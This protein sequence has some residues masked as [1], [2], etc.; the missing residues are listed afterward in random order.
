MNPER[1]KVDDLLSNEFFVKWV[2][3]PSEDLDH[4]WSNWIHD[5]PERKSDIEAARL[6]VNG[7]KYEKQ[8][9]LSDEDDNQILTNILHYRHHTA[10]QRKHISFLVS[11]PILKVAAI[12]VLIGTFLLVLIDNGEDTLMTQQEIIKHA[13]RG[14]KLTVFLPEGTKVI[15]NSDSE[16]R[17]QLPFTDV[18]EVSLIGEAFFEVQ[19]DPEKPFIVKAD[20]ITTTVLGTSFNVRSYPEEEQRTISVITGKVK[21]EDGYGHEE[22]LNP[23]IQG[24]LHVE[25]RDLLVSQFD[26]KTV[27]GWKDGLLVF[28][29]TPLEEVFKVLSRRY[30]VDFIISDDTKLKGAYSGEYTGASLDKVLKG[31]SLTSGFNYSLSNDTVTIQPKK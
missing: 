23:N 26:P 15:L 1:H 11:I 24:V 14:Q 31:I 18:R 5:H 22:S 2:H 16:I 17:Y 19:R 20:Q 29:Q 9:I 10:S 27:V 13:K 7:V 30:G 12:L 21:I 8:S 6:V 3:N 28:D 25:S 4:Y